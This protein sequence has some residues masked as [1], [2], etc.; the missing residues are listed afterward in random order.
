MTPLKIEKNIPI[1][2]RHKEVK[3]PFRTMAVGDSFFVKGT[4][5]FY[6]S[7]RDAGVKITARKMNGGF[8]VWR[9]K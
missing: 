5:G 8:R 7:A 2:A 6:P 4:E 1:P 3:Y 9:T